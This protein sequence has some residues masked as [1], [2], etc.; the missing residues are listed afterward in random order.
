ME[1]SL[2]LRTLAS[3]AGMVIISLIFGKVFSFK[4][5]E[6]EILKSNP[7][8]EAFW[9]IGLSIFIFIISILL[10]STCVPNETPSSSSIENYYTIEYAI[11]QFIVLLILIGLPLYFVLR[12][13]KQGFETV[14]FTRL[15]LL[16]S[17][18]LP[19]VVLPVIM[20]GSDYKGI[21]VGQNILKFLVFLPVGFF[22]EAMFRE[23]TYKLA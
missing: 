7:K 20:L 15:N 16:K 13:R 12:I 2:T 1:M 4:D 9:A 19:F 3:I 10:V 11:S 14:G 22:E 5:T 17:I 6:H 18:T 21:S 8:V 23:D